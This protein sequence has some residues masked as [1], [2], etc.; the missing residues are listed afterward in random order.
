MASPTPTNLNLPESLPYPIAI[1]SLLVN[2]GD[3]V[4]RGAPLCDYS[5]EYKLPATWGP[6]ARDQLR[7]KETRYGRWECP[8]DGVFDK[9]LIRKGDTV[10]SVEAAR[11]HPIAILMYAAHSIRKVPPSLTIKLP[12]QGGLP[13][14]HS[15]SWVVRLMWKGYD[16]ASPLS[17]PFLM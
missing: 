9:W 3:T 10:P 1:T 7:Q 2:P 16:R 13:S 6:S 5:F 11:M 12:P 15:D 4:P 17:P 14:Q 8:I